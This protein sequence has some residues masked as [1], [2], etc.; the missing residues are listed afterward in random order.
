M[1]E[2]TISNKMAAGRPE[3]ISAM[4]RN[5]QLELDAINKQIKVHEDKAL[6]ENRND[7]NHSYNDAVGQHQ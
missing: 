5:T 3:L 4:M 6:I 1:K 7:L 2:R